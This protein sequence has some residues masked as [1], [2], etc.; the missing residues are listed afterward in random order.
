MEGRAASGQGRAQH[1]FP[2]AG[3]QQR[4]PEAQLV[5]GLSPLLLPGVPVIPASPQFKTPWLSSCSQNAAPSMGRGPRE[6]QSWRS[7]LCPAEVSLHRNQ[8]RRHMDLLQ[9]ERLEGRGRSVLGSPPSPILYF[10]LP[11]AN[12]VEKSSKL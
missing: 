5:K 3:P 6:P 9:G 7:L 2:L 1:F 8:R 10:T 11:T 4:R 12:T